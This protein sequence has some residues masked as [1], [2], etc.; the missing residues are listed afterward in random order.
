[1]P[2][3]AAMIW[4]RFPSLNCGRV[5]EVWPSSTCGTVNMKIL[6]HTAS[7]A[8]ASMPL[9]TLSSDITISAISFSGVLLIWPMP[10]MPS[11]VSTVTTTMFEVPHAPRAV[12]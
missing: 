10:V 1:M 2:A 11:S 4:M 7:C 5:A 3:S 6:F 8:S 9:T 12:Q